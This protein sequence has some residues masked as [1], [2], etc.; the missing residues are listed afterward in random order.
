[1]RQVYTCLATGLAPE[2]QSMFAFLLACEQEKAGNRL[3]EKSWKAFISS[4]DANKENYG[5]EKVFSWMSLEVYLQPF[6]FLKMKTFIFYVMN[7]RL[8]Y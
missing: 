3:T 6:P 5:Q 7:E 8:N 4:I 2:D 1:V